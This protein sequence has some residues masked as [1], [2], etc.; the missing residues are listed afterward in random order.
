MTLQLTTFD[1]LDSLD[2]EE[3]IAEYLS[4]VMADGDDD[5]LLRALGHVAKARGMAQLAKD[6][7]VGRESLYKALKPGATPGYATVGKVVRALGFKIGVSPAGRPA[8]AS[9]KKAAA[10]GRKPNRGTKNNG[11]QAKVGAPERKK[12][13]KLAA[14]KASQTTKRR[15]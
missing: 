3:A 7:G 10:S 6:A 8:Q 5:E 4:Q 11:T 13:G 1:I 14:A 9:L 12:T 15:A 2:S